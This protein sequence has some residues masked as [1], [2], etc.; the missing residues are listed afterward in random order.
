MESVFRLK[1][2]CCGFGKLSGCPPKRSSLSR[3]GPKILVWDIIL[4]T[5]I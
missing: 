4:I 3:A 2:I 5:A 1:G